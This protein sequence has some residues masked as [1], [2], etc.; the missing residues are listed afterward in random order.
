M[1]LIFPFTS[2]LGA[3][4]GFLIIELMPELSYSQTC[5]KHGSAP[6]I[7]L[8]KN[9]Q[10]L[11]HNNSSR[12][13]GQTKLCAG[14]TA[15]LIVINHAN[16][17]GCFTQECLLASNSTIT[18]LANN[19]N[20][21]TFTASATGVKV[22]LGPGHYTVIQP[23]KAGFYRHV[24]SHECYGVISAG[25]TKRCII[26]NSYT[27]TVQTWI[28]KSNNMRI[29]FSHSPSLP[30]V[31]KITELN[32][33]VTG[34]NTSKPFELARIHMTVIKNVTATL[35]NNSMINNK[36]DFISFDNITANQ[37]VFSVKYQFLEK[38]VHQIIVKLNTKDGQV[39]LASF[40]IPVI[41]FWWNLI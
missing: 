21:Q 30:F 36:D 41:R 26:T 5:L 14:Q 39:A 27:N 12:F 32:F 35:N 7:T 23:M 4:A 33:K 34:A 3:M 19:P 15:Q 38:G 40:D 8:Y 17:T 11:F 28:D 2:L 31:G 25:E 22:V 24:F 10:A 9:T 13:N 1:L 18:I 37:G 20:P 29:Q 6:L 16:N